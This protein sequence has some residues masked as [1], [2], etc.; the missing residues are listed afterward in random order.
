MVFNDH[1]QLLVDSGNRFRNCTIDVEANQIA[2]Q[3]SEFR[4]ALQQTKANSVVTKP[5]ANSHEQLLYQLLFKPVDEFIANIESPTLIIDTDSFL[6]FLPITALYDGE[7][8]LGAKHTFVMS[9]GKQ[10][11]PSA[12]LS[13]QK[14]AGFGLTK[15]HAVLRSKPLPWVGVELDQ[16]IKED[17]QDEGIFPGTLFLDEQFTTMNYVDT[18]SAGAPI[19]H[20]TGHFDLVND[21]LKS[22]YF[23]AGGGEFLF[24]IDLLLGQSESSSPLIDVETMVLPSCDTALPSQGIRDLGT[25]KQRSDRIYEGDGLASAAIRAGAKSVLA[26]LWRVDD[27]STATFVQSVY[28]LTEQGHT[29]ADAL[30]ETRTRFINGDIQCSDATENSTHIFE[31]YRQNNTDVQAY[32]RGNWSHP[33]HWAA[34]SLF[35]GA[36]Q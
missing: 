13:E 27:A 7:Q 17:E 11:L 16:I 1:V 4:D 10:I 23:H 21:S 3:I 36:M 32:C 18:V 14:I 6:S 15:S 24:V 25:D 22:S 34:L 2:S 12:T 5:R 20:V 26:S 33:Y 29:Y 31:R 28:S 19:I 30:K 8:Y 35:V 9:K